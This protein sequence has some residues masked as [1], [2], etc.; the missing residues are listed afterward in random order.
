MKF[1]SHTPRPRQVKAYLVECFGE[2]KLLV[3]SPSGLFRKVGHS[4]H[5]SQDSVE[6]DQIILIVFYEGDQ[7]TITF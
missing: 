5:Y 2:E 1:T 6:K 7:I 4:D 3:R